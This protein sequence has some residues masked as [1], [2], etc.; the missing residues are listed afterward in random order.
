MQP[1]VFVPERDATGKP[2]WPARVVL[3]LGRST[4]RD[5]RPRAR[6]SWTSGRRGQGLD[7]GPAVRRLGPRRAARGG[8]C[9]AERT[10]RS[11][12]FVLTDEAGAFRI[13]GL[14]E[15]AYVVRA[16]EPSTLAAVTQ[17]GVQAGSEN[18]ELRFSTA[19]FAELRG[20]SSRATARRS[21]AST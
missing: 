20:A 12:A 9:W 8:R 3:Q 19:M 16:L 18:V 1:A 13:D 15:R 2:I 14:S 10:G 11:A 4:A 6:P 5:A 17:E 7:R 21:A